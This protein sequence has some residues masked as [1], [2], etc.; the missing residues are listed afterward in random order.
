MDALNV[1]P[2]LLWRKWLNLF[3]TRHFV[4]LAFGTADCA[5]HA[6]KAC[7]IATKGHRRQILS[8]KLALVF[9]ASVKLTVIEDACCNV[10]TR[11]RDISKIRQVIS[12]L[13]IGRRQ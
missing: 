2:S 5:Q 1:I 8:L 4:I 13:V 3:P 6:A 10:P 11:L 9:P 7:V 12:D